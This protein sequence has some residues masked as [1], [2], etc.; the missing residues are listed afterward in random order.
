VGEKGAMSISVEATRERANQG[1]QGLSWRPFGTVCPHAHSS[2]RSQSSSAKKKKQLFINA[3]PNSDNPRWN[4][5]P[6]NWFG[7][8]N[9]K[10]SYEG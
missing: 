4:Q 8:T 2:H 1:S 9:F 6:E 10:L 3:L 7:L 5:L